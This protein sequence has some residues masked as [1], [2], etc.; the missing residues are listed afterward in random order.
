MVGP[1]MLILKFRGGFQLVQFLS[2]KRPPQRAPT[3]RYPKVLSCPGV[4][5]F[6]GDEVPFLCVLVSCLLGFLVSRLLHFLV[7]WFQC[8]KFQNAFHLFFVNID[9][10]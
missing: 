7:S 2:L 8:F 4:G 1:N 9:P 3:T 5:M 10:I 6:R